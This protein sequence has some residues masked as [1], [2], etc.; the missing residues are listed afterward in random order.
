[1]K[2]IIV[3]LMLIAPVFASEQECKGNPKLVAACYLV[4]GRLSLGADTVTLRLWP[5]GT[6]RILGVTGGPIL[7]DSVDPIYPSTLKLPSEAEDIYGDFTVC[8]FTPE[9]KGAMQL[10]CIESASHV[11]AKRR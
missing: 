10:V 4:H 9:R 7:D 2:L 5:V 11:L 1:M 3:T 8:P 6:K